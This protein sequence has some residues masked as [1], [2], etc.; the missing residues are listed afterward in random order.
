MMSEHE[1]GI[2][3]EAQ[4]ASPAWIRIERARHP[5]RPYPMD[6]IERIFTDFSEIHGDRAYGDDEAVA[7]GMARLAGEEVM[8]IGNRKGGSIKERVRRNFGM[9]HP[10]GYRKALRVMKLA[11]KFGRPVISFID[12]PGAYPGL[13]AEERGQAEAIARN[14]LEMSRLRVP[15]ISVISGEGGSGGALALAVSDR[16]LILENALYFVIT[17]ESCAAIMWRDASHKQL[18]AEAMRISAPEVFSLGCVDEIVDEPPEGI[19]ADRETGT[20]LLGT[21]LSKHLAELKS[22]PIEDLVAARQAK[23]RNI[24]QFYTE[25]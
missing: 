7:C 23:F 4:A 8:V 21:V 1:Q 18:A 12:L 19:Q 15:T 9:P 14:I 13:G 3:T 10:E 20:G 11:E 24:A 5:Q 22:W 6:F 2:S 25:G 17:P 16:V